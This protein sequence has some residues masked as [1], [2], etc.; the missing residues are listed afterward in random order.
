[1]AAKKQVAVIRPTCDVVEI[2]GYQV[3]RTAPKARIFLVW[4]AQTETVVA[5]FGLNKGNVDVWTA[6][7]GDVIDADI[8]A[9]IAQD[10]YDQRDA[11]KADAAKQKKAATKK[12]A[13]QKSVARRKADVEVNASMM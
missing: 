6:D 1:M 4:D 5:K 12:G 13:P 10:Y 11:R 3:G 7:F 9:E 2:N 8:V